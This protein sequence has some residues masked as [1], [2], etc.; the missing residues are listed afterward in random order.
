MLERTVLR[1]AA[2][3]A[4]LVPVLIGEQLPIQIYTTAEGLTHNH[5]NRILQDGR[6]F[7]WFC[8]DGGLTRF[9]GHDFV[10]YTTQ[11]GIPHPWVNDL[12][13]A[14]DGTYWLATDGGV[15]SFNPIGISPRAPDGYHPESR[16][17]MFLTVGPADPAGARRVN[18][19]AED[20]DGSILCAT[21]AGLYRLH[22]GGGRLRFQ[23][24]EIGLP[25]ELVEGSMVNNISFS[26][27]GGWWIA[28]RHGLIHLSAEDHSNGITYAQGLPSDF[29]E[30]I[31]EDRSGRYWAGTRTAGLCE[32]GQSVI[33]GGPVVKR[34]YSVRDG[35][36]DNDVRSILQSADGTY[37]I[38]TASGL[39]E[40][41]PERPKPQ[42]RNYT[43]ANGLS[44][45]HILK[46]AE[47]ADGN[48]WMGSSV[49]GV[50][51]LVRQGFASFDSRDGFLSGSN[52]ESIVET[53]SGDLA[54]VSE[55]GGKI[56]VQVRDAGR[57]RAVDPNLPRVRPGNPGR[58]GSLQD[59]V[60]E[61][62]I[63]TDRGLFRFPKALRVSELA[64]PPANPIYTTANGFAGDNI[65]ALYEDSRGDVW[66]STNSASAHSLSRWCR[67][68][69]TLQ[70]QT[71]RSP[72]LE[73]KRCSAFGEDTAGNVW[74]GL[75]D[76]GGIVRYRQGKFE[77]VTAPASTFS[78]I[79]RAIFSDH[80]GRLWVA[81]SQ[82]GLARIEG[83]ELD[84][85]SVQR[86][87]TEEGLSS[88]DVYCVTE[89]E[90]GRIYVGTSSGVDRLDPV[91]GRIWRFT[92]ADGLVRGAILLARR[93]RA[94]ALWFVANNGVSRLIP[95]RPSPP[96]VPRVLIRRLRILGKPYP[97]SELGESDLSAV[98]VPPGQNEI[99][100]EFAAPDFRGALQYQYQLE[101]ASPGWSPVSG[102]RSVHFASLAPGDYRFLVRAASLDAAGPPAVVAFHVVPPF[103]RR[104]WFVLA[105]ISVS[106]G[107]LYTIHGLRLQRAM[108]IE[109]VRTRIA[110]DLHDDIGSSLS[111]IA[112]LSEVARQ[113]LDGQNR[114]ELEPLSKIANTSRDLL[115]SMSDI[116]WAI[117]PEKDHLRDLAQ[118]MRR[119]ASDVFTAR[120]VDFQFHGPVAEQDVGIGA[121][122][123][124]QVFLIF[125]ESVNNAVRH[126]GCNRVEIELAVEK[127]W[128]RL[129]IRDNGHGLDL[130]EC[131]KGNGLTSMRTRAETLGGF[132]EL[133]SEQGTEIALEI[134]LGRLK[135][136]R[137]AKNSCLD[138]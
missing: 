101:G 56:V 137:K 106:A 47:D 96:S 54:I 94:G 123:R 86:Y 41:H 26:P 61:W 116:V 24:V 63:G 79:V 126:S 105:T 14:R 25:K 110:T 28:A 55:A 42:F 90:S 2:S 99:Q 46:L 109:R 6:G 83:A 84:R 135:T 49:G 111:Q 97:I 100:V 19:L 22:R 78:G 81:S 35:L 34:C 67:D 60:G 29:V 36:A 121:D 114:P 33:L 102:G 7:L 134:P 51:K 1:A 108:E 130:S 138:G 37:W 62:W 88:N 136:K 76:D 20:T 64:H 10:S 70:H 89:D 5:I 15:V 117:N 4:L 66:I 11:D 75:V 87:S 32:I 69:A 119:F 132:L 91:N 118:R 57:F 53:A 18:A 107:V 95:G 13:I 3:I 44:D 16:A 125:K 129:R 131:Q 12:L 73:Q 58:S 17:P 65:V 128:L 40:F 38:G 120:H 39:S 27:R 82:G 9:D 48:L 45:S 72:L 85:P 71:H 68:T 21:Y 113:N 124:R 93:D 30:T 52:Q 104:W 31:Y 112:I 77:P 43:A 122:V 8:T 74:I 98:I 115:H 80:A 133:R 59:R 23:P 127:H 103:W 92:A 50:M